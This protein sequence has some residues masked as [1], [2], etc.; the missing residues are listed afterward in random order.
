MLVS[1]SAS[2]ELRREVAAGERPRPEY[3]ELERRGVEL[4]DWSRLPGHPRARSA[5][6]S[7]LQVAV[8]LPR[9][10]HL[11]AVFSD[12]EHVGIPLALAMLAT[13]A[14]TPH[15][16]LGH[17][18]TNGRKPSLVRRLR[19]GRRIDRIVLHSPRQLEL[20][21]GELGV[22]GARL[23]LDPFYADTDFWRPEPRTVE[24]PLILAAGREH[25]DYATLA[26][27]W[28]GRPERVLVAAG[29]THSP[30][31]TTR[32]PPRWP[33]TFDICVA[34]PRQ[35]RDGYARASAV[36]VPVVESD[37]QAGV[38]VVLE[39]MAMG[40][41]VV[42]TAARGWADVIE[43]GVDGLLVPPGDP[44]AL[45]AALTR[46]LEDESLR[47]RLGRAARNAAVTRFSLPAYADRL[48]ALLAEVAGAA[49]AAA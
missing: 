22:S 24:E 27:A 7:A 12:G 30:A 49:P 10:R 26:E 16:M 14:H 21:R 43:D 17:H 8:A 42:A 18:L 29:S 45:R 48:E 37:F 3:L 31:A 46:V 47:A 35:L 6:T 39:A 13:G 40:K 25:R 15:L 38:T 1:A 20:A 19:L 4:L 33:D 41:A 32:V 11:D 34:G 2:T 28:A 44:R 5:R 9:L 23:A 36:V